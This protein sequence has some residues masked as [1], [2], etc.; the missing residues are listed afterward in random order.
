LSPATPTQ[1]TPSEPTGADRFTLLRHNAGIWQGTFIRL[2]GQG[3][4]QERFG[5]HLEVAER[6]GT[7]H[8]DLTNRSSGR[9][10][11]M[12]FD[13]PPA[14]M[15]ISPAGHWS[16]GPNR[17]GPW[18]WVCELCLVWGEQRRRIVVRHGLGDLETLV[19]VSE[20][21][22]GHEPTPP[23]SPL[24]VLPQSVDPHHRL[25]RL[26]QQPSVT[27]TTMAGREPGLAEAV[28]L[29]W[30]PEPGIALSLVRRYDAF[31]LLQAL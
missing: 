23:A 15:Q 14:E 13:Q 24:Q 26:E 3:C 7:I 22:P 27:V 21:R 2:D 17:I 30:E 1:H 9:V 12:Q 10:R 31:G 18:S 5:S 6:Q 4:E 11:S 16:L 28:S 8:A 19:L 25:W 20:G 29:M